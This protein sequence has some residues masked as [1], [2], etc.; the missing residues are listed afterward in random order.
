MSEQAKQLSIQWAGVKIQWQSN[1]RLRW[2][3]YLV[4]LILLSSLALEV[5]DYKLVQQ[6][7]LING[8]HRLLQVQRTAGQKEWLPWAEQARQQ[9]EAFNQQLWQAETKGIAQATLQAWL[10][11]HVL[12]NNIDDARLEVEK[13]QENSLYP[14]Y[15]QVAA[16]INGLFEVQKLEAL[17]KTLDDERRNIIVQQL[18]VKKWGRSPRFTLIL[19]AWFQPKE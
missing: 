2:L 4:L 19:Y 16:K 5:R 12:Q 13:V 10:N 17:L 6:E 18:D 14:G 9:L 1:Q 8:Q 3:S 7:A 11:Q 15:W